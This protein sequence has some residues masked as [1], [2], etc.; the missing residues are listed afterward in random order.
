MSETL[1]VTKEELETLINQ[2]IQDAKLGILI[3]DFQAHK[4]EEETRWAEMFALVRAFPEKMAG[5]KESLESDIYKELEDHY[6]TK[7][8]VKLL[9][10]ELQSQNREMSNKFKWTVGVL[11]FIA[12]AIQFTTTIVYMTY[13]ISKLST[14]G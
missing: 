4:S 5:C 10:Q 7:A 8:D 14:G 11:V 3:D 13:Q 12:G 2:G 9:K 6:V 1:K